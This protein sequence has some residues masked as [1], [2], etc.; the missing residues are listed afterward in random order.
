MKNNL[1]KNLLAELANPL[2]SKIHRF[3]DIHKGTSCY[4]MG[5]GISIKWFDLTVFSDKIVLP[6]GFIPFHNDFNRLDVKYLLLLEPF[7]FYPLVSTSSPPIK[8]ISN[9]IQIEY[10][11]I[12]KNN[13]DKANL[14]FAFI[15]GFL[16]GALIF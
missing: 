13:P 1:L 2:L 11:N 16:F 12:I 8:L 10:R 3:K 4:L 5:D 14:A 9:K 6:C 7:W 15:F